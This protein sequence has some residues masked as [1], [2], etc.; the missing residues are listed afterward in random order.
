MAKLKL[1]WVELD[2]GMEYR[3]G[4]VVSDPDGG[5][6]QNPTVVSIKVQGMI[7]TL[8]Y[9]NGNVRKAKWNDAKYVPEGEPCTEKKTASD[10]VDAADSE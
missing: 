6:N 1:V 8:E 9:S 7:A 10:A 2:D 5:E 4:K 3:I